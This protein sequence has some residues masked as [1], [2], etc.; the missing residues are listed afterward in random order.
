MTTQA[1]ILS[2]KLG[3]F[4]QMPPIP[5]GTYSATVTSIPKIEK[6]GRKQNLGAEFSFKLTGAQGDVDSD[7]LRAAGG[8]PDEP[9]TYTF[10]LTPKAMIIVQN[11]L[12]D[13]LG[14][15]E[16]TSITD[17]LAQVVGASCLVT[18]AHGTSKRGNAF[19]QIDG[20]AKAD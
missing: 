13:V 20:F 10:W 18:I 2:M 4:K 8:L 17:A 6:M 7:D 16:G 5:L 11:V 14:V 12:V 15:A 9:L 19:A 1:D 3:D